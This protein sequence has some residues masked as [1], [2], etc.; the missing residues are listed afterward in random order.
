MK[1][2]EK[3]SLEGGG[4]FED[5]KND[6]GGRQRGEEGG[7]GERERERERETRVGFEIC[8]ACCLLVYLIKI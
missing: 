8:F 1:G 3:N 4:E 7:G 5:T 6:D 2:G